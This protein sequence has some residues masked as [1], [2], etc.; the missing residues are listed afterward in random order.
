MVREREAACWMDKR[1][2]VMQK[3]E[4]IYGRWKS[5]REVSNVQYYTIEHAIK[6]KSIFLVDGIIRRRPTTPNMIMALLKTP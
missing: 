4:D 1:E 3:Q 5:Q 6:G 2:G